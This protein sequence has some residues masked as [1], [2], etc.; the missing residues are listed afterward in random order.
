MRKFKD[1]NKGDVQDTI[2]ALGRYLVAHKNRHSQDVYRQIKNGI[3]TSWSPAGYI[4]LGN[5][6]FDIQVSLHLKKEQ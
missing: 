2:E 3:E 1:T 6:T 4:T 5:D